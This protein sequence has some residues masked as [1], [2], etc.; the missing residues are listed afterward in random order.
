[1]N[2]HKLIKIALFTC[3][4]NVTHAQM[5]NSIVG[6]GISAIATDDKM[7]RENLEANYNFHLGSNY[8]QYITEGDHSMRSFVTDYIKVLPTD[9]PEIFTLVG[10]KRKTDSNRVHTFRAQFG[11]VVI[12]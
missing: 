10:K 2:I 12:E 3:I 6:I 1:M 11:T 5:I 4:V 9:K 7:G 8:Q